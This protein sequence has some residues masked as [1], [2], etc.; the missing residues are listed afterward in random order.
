MFKL[1][2]LED[3]PKDKPVSSELYNRI[4]D[5]FHRGGPRGSEFIKY[6]INKVAIVR[7]EGL[8]TAF[9]TALQKMEARAEAAP[10]VFEKSF[11]DDGVKHMLKKRLEDHFL[12]HPS[13]K[14]VKLLLAWH[15]TA[16]AIVPSICSHGTADLRTTDGG[17]FG[18]GTYVTPQAGWRVSI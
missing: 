15:G 9:V 5:R 18:S 7:N 3:S 13:L 2:F 1:A 4:V 11:D 17:F 6:K 14:H 8:V 12:P 10:A 16:F